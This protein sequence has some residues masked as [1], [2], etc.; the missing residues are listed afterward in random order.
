M[1]QAAL[2][3]QAHALIAKGQAGMAEARLK[4]ELKGGQSDYPLLEMLAY[5][6]LSQS[7]PEGA[8]RRLREAIAADSKPANAYF[9]AGGVCAQMGRLQEAEEFFAKALERDPGSLQGWLARGAALSASRRWEDGLSCYRAAL[10]LSPRNAE[11]RQGEGAMLGRMGRHAEALESFEAALQI[12]SNDAGSLYNKARSLA[13]LN[14]YE[15]AVATYDLAARFAPNNP[16]I[17]INRGVA[18]EGLNRLAE[19]MDS[20]ERAAQVGRKG[21]QDVSAALFNK[22]AIML[23]AGDYANGFKLYGHRVAVM[24]MSDTGRPIGDAPLWEGSPIQGPL[25]VWMEQGIGD[26]ILYSRLLPLVRARAPDLHWEC[27]RRLAGPMRRAFPEVDIRGDDNPFR[28]ASAQISSADLATI[29][30]LSSPK[31]LPEAPLWS[32]QPERATLLRER[33]IGLAQGRPIV[34]IA[35]AS[36]NA[37][38]GVFKGAPIEVWAP[39]LSQDYFF[40]SLQYGDVASDIARARE[41]FGCEI[42]VDDEVDQMADLEAFFAQVSALDHIAS[43]SNT[44]AHVAGALGKRAQIMLPPNR[45]LHWY[46]GDKGAQCAWYPSLTLVRRDLAMS[47]TDQIEIAA[48]AIETELA[49]A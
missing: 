19:A 2:L 7:D 23:A 26:Q 27:E 28:D 44:T 20:Y 16:K 39:L 32:P 45:G 15:E 1:S 5:A 43:I 4:A 37:K 9:N 36:K 12:A 22:C 8:L 18:L 48:R 33:Y 49:S 25:R 41:L 3:S 17:W 21:S 6:R 40:V 13:A 35:W 10:K 31:E 11:A 29:L 30:G 14:R 47:W 24:N 46:W 38:A 34:G 42:F